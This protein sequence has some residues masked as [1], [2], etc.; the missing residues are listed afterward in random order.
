LKS[1]IVGGWVRDRLC[2]RSVTDK[3]WVVVGGSEEK[4][5]EMGFEKV[6][7]SFPVFLHPV[8]KEEYA[9]ARLERK[10]GQGYHGFEVDSSA[11]VTL[12]EDL[13]R[14]DLTINAMAFDLETQSFIDPYHGQSD[15]E[16]GVLRHVSQAFIEDPLRVL[17]LARFAAYFPTFSLAPETLQLAIQ[18]SNSGELKTLSLERVTQEIIKTYRFGLNPIRFWEVLDQVGALNE[19]FKGWSLFLPQMLPTMKT[20]PLTF[21]YHQKFIYIM[22]CWHQILMNEPIVALPEKCLTLSVF[23]QKMIRFFI[24]A[25][26]ILQVSPPEQVLLELIFMTKALHHQNNII[27]LWPMLKEPILSTIQLIDLIKELNTLKTEWITQVEPI[28][29]RSIQLK[30]FYKKHILHFLQQRGL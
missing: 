7:A 9:L 3:D 15:L 2:N 8:T 14:R 4:L 21:S 11:R 22:A 13:F 28:S 20:M 17:R 18:I 24:E 10:K 25:K 5:I 30:D 29:Q 27:F 19:L 1:Y 16:K 23:E 6:G 12:E 26:R